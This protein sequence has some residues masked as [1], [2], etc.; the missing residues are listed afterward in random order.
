MGKSVSPERVTSLRCG[1]PQLD[2]SRIVVMLGSA[3]KPRH[4]RESGKAGKRHVS[5]RKNVLCDVIKPYE[6]LSFT[7]AK[8]LALWPPAC[9]SIS[10]CLG[11]CNFAPQP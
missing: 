9:N 11:I 4:D 1:Q 8:W 7:A 5:S 6:S 2:L 3:L 10:I